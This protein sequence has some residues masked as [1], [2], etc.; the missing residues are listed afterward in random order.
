MIDL[1]LL[2]GQKWPSPV[3][4]NVAQLLGLCNRRVTNRDSLIELVQAVL[5]I[6]EDRI[7]LVSISDCRDTYQVPYI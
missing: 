4:K 2:E 3:Y 1:G 6:P 5:A 7:A